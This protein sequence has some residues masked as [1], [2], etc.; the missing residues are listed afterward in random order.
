MLIQKAGSLERVDDLAA[1][2]VFYTAG[3]LDSIDPL[4]SPAQVAALIQA[5]LAATQALL[6]KRDDDRSLSEVFAALSAPLTDAS[7]EGDDRG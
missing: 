7:V 6:S 1:A 3:Q 5:H 2:N 4:T